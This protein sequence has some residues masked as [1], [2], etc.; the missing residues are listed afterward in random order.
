M[1]VAQSGTGAPALWE[2]W[3]VGHPPHRSPRLEI[4]TWGA[5]RS[6]S[7]LAMMR[8]KRAKVPVQVSP[9]DESLVLGIKPRELLV[10]ESGNRFQSGSSKLQPVI[11]EH[12]MHGVVSDLRLVWRQF[13]KSPGFAITAV[14]ML[15][16]GIGATTAIFSLVDGVLL[17]PLPLPQ[18]NRLVTLG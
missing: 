13:R 8:S 11:E 10:M 12:L 1:R 5:R 16:F 2:M 9:L 18:A 17:L 6:L 15:A 3:D 14:L 7:A 4:E